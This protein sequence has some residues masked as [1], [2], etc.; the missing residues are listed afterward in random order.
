MVGRELPC[1]ELGTVAHGEQT[2][3]YPV[4]GPDTLKIAGSIPH[5]PTY[6]PTP[7]TKGSMT[8]LE[9]EARYAAN[10]GLTV[11]QLREHGRIVVPCSC[12]YE[13]CQG[14]ASYPADFLPDLK[15]M[16]RVD[17]NWSWPPAE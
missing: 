5:G 9:F 3:L 10:G 11:E 12:D 16:G 15:D 14:W 1:L 8:A 17:P 4:V 13:G 6:Q 2:G 7:S